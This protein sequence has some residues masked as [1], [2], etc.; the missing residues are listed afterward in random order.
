M[1]ITYTMEVGWW[2][3][4]TFPHYPGASISMSGGA[5]RGL[6]SGEAQAQV[7]LLLLWNLKWGVGACKP[8]TV[9]R[10]PPP[11][12]VDRIPASNWLAS[13]V[14]KIDILSEHQGYVKGRDFSKATGSHFNKRGHDILDMR[15]TILE[16]LHNKN[17]LYRK[18]RE[19]MWIIKINTKYKGMNRNC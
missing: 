9:E 12:L 8:D 4:S 14:F 5:R 10:A 18:E 3:W 2:C 13:G 1:I 19:S 16:K 15:I 17:I 6:G 11:P 7:W